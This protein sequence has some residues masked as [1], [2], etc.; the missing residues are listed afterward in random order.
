MTPT[1]YQKQIMK[2]EEQFLYHLL[3]TRTNEL[4]NGPT[5]EQTDERTDEIPIGFCRFLFKF[6][7]DLRFFSLVSPPSSD[8]H[9]V[10][11]TACV[12]YGLRQ[13]I[14]C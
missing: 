14:P 1:T 10:C 11:V 9:P 4:S 7:E 2:R 3:K 6:I 12:Y 13:P 5:D 8:K